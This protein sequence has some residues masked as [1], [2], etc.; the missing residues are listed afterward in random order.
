MRSLFLILLIT[1]LAACSA[2]PARLEVPLGA[3]SPAAFGQSLAL[4]QQ[5]TVERRGEARSIEAVLAISP[6]RIDLA[7]LAMG[8]RLIDVHFDGAS[9]TEKR[10][11]LLPDAVT[12]ARILR[13]VMLAYWPREALMAA[14]P[15]GWRIEDAAG[16]RRVLSGDERVITI[17]YSGEPRWRG[18]AH[19]IQHRLGYSL[20]IDSDE[21]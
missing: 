10:S 1:A 2:P 4:T 20:T 11:P 13:D 6:E 9:I 14:L 7:G 18:R 19:L 15:T 12:G 17:E 3:V 16:Q 8:Q 5:I 21:A